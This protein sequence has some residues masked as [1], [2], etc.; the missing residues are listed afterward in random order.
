MNY[1]PQYIPPG[2]DGNTDEYYS[3]PHIDVV[4]KHLRMCGCDLYEFARRYVPDREYQAEVLSR[5]MAE[6]D[7]NEDLKTQFDKYRKAALRVQLL[8]AEDNLLRMAQPGN[9]N[10]MKALEKAIDMLQH[11]RA[12]VESSV[13]PQAERAQKLASRLESIDDADPGHQKIL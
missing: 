4:M 5:I 12:A 1:H 10:S 11:N 7:D 8:Q 2:Q 9:T 3:I 6:I 13:H